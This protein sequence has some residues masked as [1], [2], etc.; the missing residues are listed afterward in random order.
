[1]TTLRTIAVHEVVQRTYP[2]PPRPEDEVGKAVGRAIDGTQSHFSHEFRQGRRPTATAMRTYG[3]ALLQEELAQAALEL[4]PSD[5][6]SLLAQLNGTLQAF[7]KSPA[8]GLARPR[9]RLLVIDRRVGVYAQPDFWDARRRFFEVKSY[10]ALP[11]PPD[12]ALQMRLFQLAFPGFE[13]VLLCIDRHTT[14]VETSALVVPPPTSEETLDALRLAFD[15]GEE[16]GQPKVLEYLEG[17][18]VYYD[19]PG[20]SAGPP[21]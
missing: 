3:E 10:R 7:R 1:M 4:T 13:S 18:F 15:L 11:P 8:F 17:P 19:R 16:F 2:R 9:S 6:A 5:L 14:P 12:V 20:N 21:G